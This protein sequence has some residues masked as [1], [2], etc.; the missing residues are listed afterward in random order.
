LQVSDV[1]A[2]EHWSVEVEVA[3]TEAVAGLDEGGMR[4]VVDRS[5]FVEAPLGLE[6]QQCPSGV[7]SE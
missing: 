2:S 4:S 1:I 3:V 6:G 5:V 7:G